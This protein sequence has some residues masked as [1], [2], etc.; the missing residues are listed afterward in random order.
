[1]F[2]TPISDTL[3]LRALRTELENAKKQ[4]ATHNSS[5][6]NIHKGKDAKQIAY[7]ENE[8]FKIEL[9]IKSTLNNAKERLKAKK[10]KYD[11]YYNSI[12]AVAAKYDD[13]I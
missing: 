13:F 7:L 3:K 2:G 12:M 5:F 8:I 4:Q 9:C 10:E 11:D 1:M 6:I